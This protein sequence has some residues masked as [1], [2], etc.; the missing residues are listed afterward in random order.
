MELYF[1]EHWLEKKFAFNCVNFVFDFADLTLNV[2]VFLFVISRGAIPIYL[3][4]EV[5]DNLTRLG[6]S[7]HSMYK[8]RQFIGKIKRLQDVI[9]E[10]GQELLCCICLGNISKGKKLHCSHVFHF[11]CLKEWLIE[12]YEC[13]TCRS[14]VQLD[15]PPQRQQE[16]LGQRR[17]LERMLQE[18]NEQRFGAQR[19]PALTEQQLGG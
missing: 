14:P 8:S 2:R 18:R 12:R 19:R 7:L 4:G 3:L 15:A 11:V 13:P 9:P 5:V 16:N 6:T 17:D 1:G 10:E